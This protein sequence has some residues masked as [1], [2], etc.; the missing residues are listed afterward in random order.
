MCF[1]CHKVGEKNVESFIFSSFDEVYDHWKSSHSS[2]GSDTDA[3]S[4]DGGAEALKPF[5]FYSVD[6]LCCCV[7]ACSFYS[8]FRGL[9]R[10]HQKKHPN[11][12][13]VP[14]FNGRCA[15]C[16]YTGDDLREHSC[17]SLDN[18]VQ[19]QLC[20]PILLTDQELAELQAIDCQELKQN[21]TKHFECQ[22]CDGF[23]GSRQE[24]IQHY[25]ESHG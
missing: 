3:A 14:I 1:Y 22:Y 18:V 4:S 17:D 20:N 2:D 10:H 12:L 5:R 16:F 7:D 9:H 8:T 21:R 19:L 15:L 23:L 13:F 24:M 11:N 25:D 6:L